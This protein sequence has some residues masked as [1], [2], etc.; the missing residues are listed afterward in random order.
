MTAVMPEI[1]ACTT[2]RPGLGRAHLADRDVLGRVRRAPVGAVVRR[3]DDHLRA[4]VHERPHLVAERRLEADDR[5]DLVPGDRRRARGVGP[6]SKSRGTWLERADPALEQPRG[7]AR[8]RRTA[9]GGAWRTCPR[10]VPS[11]ANS[12]SRF[13]SLRRPSGA[14]RRRVALASTHACV[15]ARDR[16]RG[17][18][19]RY[20][21]VRGSASM[22]DS[23]NTIEVDRVGDLRGASSK[24]LFGQVAGLRSRRR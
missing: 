18:S 13:S 20:G 24:W 10:R 23:G 11:G 5:R 2:G 16:R 22:L 8:T 15:R 17:G 7:T 19:R 3:H 12:T 1:A 9:R 14:R 6:G 4:V 21:S